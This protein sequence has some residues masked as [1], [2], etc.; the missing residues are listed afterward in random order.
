MSLA[1]EKIYLI[2]C[3]IPYTRGIPTNKRKVTIVHKNSKEVASGDNVNNGKSFRKVVAQARVSNHLLVTSTQR[4]SASETANSRSRA[5]DAWKRIQRSRG[6]VD[7][8]RSPCACSFVSEARGRPKLVEDSRVA[9]G[10]MSDALL[11]L[12]LQCPTAAFVGIVRVE[13]DAIW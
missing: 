8:E 9:P 11:K 4:G 6:G 10:R 5:D 13:G 1:T 3:G 2:C 7:E 12:L